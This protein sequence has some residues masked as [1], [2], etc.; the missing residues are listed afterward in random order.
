MRD[1][2]TI[3]VRRHDGEVTRLGGDAGLAVTMYGS[4]TTETPGRDIDPPPVSLR[5]DTPMQLAVMLASLLATIS[6]V[7]GTETVEMAIAISSIFDAGRPAARRV[8]P[9]DKEPT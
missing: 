9:S 7:A 3:D 4:P 1:R 6:E 2:I 8:L 5:A